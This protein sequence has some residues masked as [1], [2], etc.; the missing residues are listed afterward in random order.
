MA[1]STNVSI[2]LR[3]NNKGTTKTISEKLFNAMISSNLEVSFELE[4]IKRS[5]RNR[6]KIR[7]ASKLIQDII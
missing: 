7:S 4:G 6:R 1:K 2:A 5:D 3:G